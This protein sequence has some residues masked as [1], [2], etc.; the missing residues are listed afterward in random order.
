[1]IL[2]KVKRKRAS[3]SK[4]RK[5]LPVSQRTFTLQRHDVGVLQERGAVDEAAYL[6]LGQL[7]GHAAELRGEVGSL[8]AFCVIQRW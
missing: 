3:D 6:V 8:S 1:M 5:R 4:R 7:A 2:K